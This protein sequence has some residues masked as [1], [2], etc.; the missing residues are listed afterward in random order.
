MRRLRMHPRPHLLRLVA[1]FIIM[2]GLW[3]GFVSLASAQESTP[4]AVTESV[5]DEVTEASVGDGTLLLQYYLCDGD[6]GFEITVGDP[7]QPSPDP[8]VTDCTLATA[9]D[10]TDATFLIYLSGDLSSIPQ[11]VTTV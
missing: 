8:V 6:V 10:G 4:E 9:I 2:L 3:G 5:D 1:A 11:E 7:N